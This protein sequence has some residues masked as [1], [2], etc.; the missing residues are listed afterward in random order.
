[1]ISIRCDR[2]GRPIRYSRDPADDSPGVCEARG[3]FLCADCFGEGDA[4]GRC[5]ECRQAAEAA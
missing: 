4:K 3:E 2:C 5:E 1:M